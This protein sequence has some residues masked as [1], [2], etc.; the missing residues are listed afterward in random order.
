[1]FLKF[2]HRGIRSNVKMGQKGKTNSA[3]RDMLNIF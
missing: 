1:M 2:D 3:L